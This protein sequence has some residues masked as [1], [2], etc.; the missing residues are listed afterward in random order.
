MGDSPSD[1]PILEIDGAAFD[2]F[3][4]FQREFSR[5]LD[6]YVWQ[7]NLDAF[8]DILRGGFGTPDGGW[9]LRW[10]CADRSRRVLGHVATVKRLEAI[11]VTCHSSNRESVQRRLEDARRGVGA[12]LFDEIVEIVRVH[13]PHGREPKGGVILELA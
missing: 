4:G 11:L 7:G 1:V 6:D 2:D 12:T 8:N 3:E 10:R 9:V 5:L 13:G